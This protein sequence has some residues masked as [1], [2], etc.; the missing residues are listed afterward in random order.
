M[1][2]AVIKRKEKEDGNTD[3]QRRNERHTQRR[4]V[5]SVKRIQKKSD[6]ITYCSHAV[7]AVCCPWTVCD[8]FGSDCSRRA[9]HL[10]LPFAFLLSIAGR[11]CLKLKTGKDYGIA[12]LAGIIRWD[13]IGYIRTT[14]LSGILIAMTNILFFFCNTILAFLAAQLS[15]G[16][17]SA[18]EY[19]TLDAW[20]IDNTSTEENC[21][22]AQKKPKFV[23]KL[24]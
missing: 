13:S 20:I 1:W 10:F 6:I 11:T 17:V 15:L 12:A 2:K 16:I 14:V 23:S 8:S 5:S 3:R 7:W 19:G 18:F 9:G 4:S 24:M 22:E 21:H